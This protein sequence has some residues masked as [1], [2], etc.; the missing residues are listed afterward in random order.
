MNKGSILALIF[1]L[2]I[3]VGCSS[4]TPQTPTRAA[5]APTPTR[6][7]PVGTVLYQSDWSRGLAAWGNLPGWIVAQGM[8]QSDINDD[9]LTLPYR[10]AVPD[11]ALEVRFRVVSVPDY[12]G[13]F[14]VRADHTPSKDGYNAGILNL[15]G[16]EMATPQAQVSVDP[17]GDMDTRM[18]ASDYEPGSGWHTYRIEVRGPRVS[19]FI[20][21]VRKSFA[22]SKITKVLSNGPFRM[23]SLGAIINVSSARVMTL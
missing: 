14:E 6:S 17:T 11:Y 19:F 23:A 18:I 8:V 22:T 21:G 10:S 4:G 16:S 12:G 3:L 7:V 2:L 13:Y 1:L 9:V 15:L 20:D 5:V